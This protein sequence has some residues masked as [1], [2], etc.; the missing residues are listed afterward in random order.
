MIQ[1][2]EERLQELMRGRRWFGPATREIRAV[3]V[4]DAAALNPSG[5]GLVLALVEVE[6]PDRGK[7]LFHLP[8]VRTVDGRFEDVSSASAALDAL[9]HA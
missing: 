3:R 5:E 9:S 2:P 6:T 1:I 4:V 8:L 7:E